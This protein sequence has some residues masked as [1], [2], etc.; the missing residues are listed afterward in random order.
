MNENKYGRKKERDKTMLTYRTTKQTHVVTKVIKS[1]MFEVDPGI[2]KEIAL[3]PPIQAPIAA[4]MGASVGA[5]VSPT[6]R[7]ESD[8][9]HVFH[10]IRLKNIYVPEKGT[11]ADKKATDYLKQLIVGKR[12]IFNFHPRSISDDHVGAYVWR[13]PDNAFVNAIM[14]YS[15]HA[16]WKSAPVR[17]NMPPY[18]PP[19]VSRI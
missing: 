4:A 5:S 16:E 15:G 7:R 11:L 12:V 17:V 8:D 13:F 18:L 6:F 19:R 14:V 1:D 9:L 2:P 10:T 3:Q